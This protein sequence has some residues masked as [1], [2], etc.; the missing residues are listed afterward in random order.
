MLASDIKPGMLF[1]KQS[2]DVFELILIVGVTKDEEYVRV[3]M[4]ITDAK[5]QHTY[6]TNF[7]FKHDTRVYGTWVRVQS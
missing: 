7:T 3:V 4:M 1:H 6:T 5:A 2:I